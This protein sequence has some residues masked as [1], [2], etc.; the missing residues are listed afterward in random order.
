MAELHLPQKDMEQLDRQFWQSIDGER[1]AFL[2]AHSSDDPPPES[3]QSGK[4]G[5]RNPD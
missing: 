2:S 3:V 4:P 1:E 5:D